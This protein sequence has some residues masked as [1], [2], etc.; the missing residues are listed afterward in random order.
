MLNYE[1]YP[2]GTAEGAK[3]WIENRIMPGSFLTAVIENNLREAL[4][5]ADE[6]NRAALFE[7][8]S[9]WYNEAPSSCWGSPEKAK[10]WAE[11]RE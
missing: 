9:W 10:E 1:K 5:C 7:I 6:Y 11:G 3:L 4:G 8:V 2:G